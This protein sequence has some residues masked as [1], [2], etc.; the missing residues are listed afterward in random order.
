MANSLQLFQT[1]LGGGPPD[2][3]SPK[4]KDVLLQN[5]YFKG[6]VFFIAMINA[7]NYLIT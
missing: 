6:S 7:G 3:L 5:S 4:A 1:F 2:E